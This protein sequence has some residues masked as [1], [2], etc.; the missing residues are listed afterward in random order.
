MRIV[1]CI[2][3]VLGILFPLVGL[4]LV[5]VWLLDFFVIKR[6]PA[7]KRFLNA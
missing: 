3:V 2:I 6:I 4:S 5:I 1:T 7:L